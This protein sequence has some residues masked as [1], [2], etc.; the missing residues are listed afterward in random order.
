M[1]PSS[2]RPSIISSNTASR[3]L[4]LYFQALNPRV[5]IFS[6]YLKVNNYCVDCAMLLYNFIF[7]LM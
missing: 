5:S 1:S 3:Y 4:W 7:Y 6:E 2:L